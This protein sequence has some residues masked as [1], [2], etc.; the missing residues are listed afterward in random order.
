MRSLSKLPYLIALF[1]CTLASNSFASQATTPENLLTTVEKL[2]SRY[3]TMSSLV[4]DFYQHTQGSVTG[5]PKVGKGAAKFLKADSKSFM[6]WDYNEPSKQ[7]LTSDGTVFSMYFEEMNQQIVTPAENLESDITYSFFTG[8]GN[9][10]EDFDIL[11]PDEHTKETITDSDKVTIVKL[12][13]NKSESQVQNIHLW[14]REDALI[15]RIQIKDHFDTVTTLSFGNIE[16]DTLKDIQTAR[17]L[18]HF[19]PP[20]GTEIIQ[21]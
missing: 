6:R 20:A 21:Q 18:F 19:D 11:A 1:C 4:F 2:Q 9:L 13:P 12:V 15:S 16:V 7:V 5:R 3:D 8:K 10:I 17:A 14:V